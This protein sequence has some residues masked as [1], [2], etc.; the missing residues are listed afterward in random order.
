MSL[1]KQLKSARMDDATVGNTVDNHMGDLEQAL[2]DIF[3]ITVNVD[4]TAAPFAISAAGLVVAAQYPFRWKPIACKTNKTVVQAISTGNATALTFD[5]D[6]YDTA[7][8]HDSAGSGTKITVP[9]TGLYRVSAY[10][11]WETSAAGPSRVLTLRKNGVTTLREVV[12]IAT[13]SNVCAQHISEPFSLT[14]AD[15]I[16]VLGTQGSGG[17]LNIE[18]TAFFSVEYIGELV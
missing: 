8:L 13:A 16:E 14:A 17:N 7:T 10:L 12:D 18:D 15:Y 6:E 4:V 2:C 5:N 1:P 3:G 9:T 11:E